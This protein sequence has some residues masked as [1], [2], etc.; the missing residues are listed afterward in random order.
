MA[1]PRS[2]SVFFTSQPQGHFQFLFSILAA[3]RCYRIKHHKFS[4]FMQ[5]KLPILL[6][7]RLKVGNE[8]HIAQIKGLSRLRLLEAPEEVCFLDFQLQLLGSSYI[9]HLWPPSCDL[10][11]LSS[12]PAESSSYFL[13]LSLSQAL[14]SIPAI[15]WAQQMV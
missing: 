9:L 7:Y 3:S 8:F 4:I 11:P 12:G 14:T 6:Y 15:T 2:A 10:L 5:S 13:F 1:W